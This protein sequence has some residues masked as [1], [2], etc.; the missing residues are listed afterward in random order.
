MSAKKAG[1]DQGPTSKIPTTKPNGHSITPSA[2]STTTKPVVAVKWE[3]QNALL[4]TSFQVATKAVALVLVA[5]MDDRGRCFP[6]QLLIAQR[7]SLKPR[8]VRN[9]L[10]IL[11]DSGW[12][13]VTTRG[14]RKGD[15]STVSSRYQAIL[16]LSISTGTVVPLE[17][18]LDPYVDD[19][20]T[21]STG[22]TVPL[23]DSQPARGGLSTGTTV[24]PKHQE[25]SIKKELL[26]AS[27]DCA[28]TLGL[29]IENTSQDLA[30]IEPTFTAQDV[31][32][33]Y[34]DEWQAL[35]GTKALKR[36]IGQIA[37]SAR[38]LLDDG[39]SPDLVIE[40]AKHCAKDGHANLS[41]SVAWCAAGATRSRPVGAK[42]HAMNEA[43]A[44]VQRF[45]RA[46]AEQEH[47]ELKEISI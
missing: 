37:R 36:Q 24:P 33:V 34:V 18:S 14:H 12:L 7:A 4:A 32:K 27:P 45:E 11:I 35:H 41:S 16:P 5:C 9:H 15:G 40:A 42:T 43:L 44:M 2:D 29:L 38:E 23:E 3:W 46:D 25:T 17:V 8:A 31:V 1:P 26:P 13:T 22:T 6:S 19:A 39:Q 30:I 10:R 21:N 47:R 28:S 20:L